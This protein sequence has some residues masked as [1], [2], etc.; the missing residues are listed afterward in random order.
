M[1]NFR[2]QHIKHKE[3]K[4]IHSHKVSSCKLSH[5]AKYLETIP[6]S[7]NYLI[8]GLQNELTKLGILKNQEDYE[9]FWKLTQEVCAIK[10]LTL[11]TSARTKPVK[12]HNGFTNIGVLK[13][14]MAA[15]L[16]QSAGTCQ[17]PSH[18]MSKQ[19]TTQTGT[20]EMFPKSKP[21]KRNR[22][23]K[24]H[25]HYLHHMH[26]FSLVNMVSSKRMLEKNGQFSGVRT[27]QSVHDLMEYLFP[28]RHEQSGMNHNIKIMEENTFPSLVGSKQQEMNHKVSSKMY[29][30][31]KE[32]KGMLK[33]HTNKVVGERAEDE[34]CNV[35]TFAQQEIITVPLT[36]EDA[37][38]Y[39][40]VVEVK[41]RGTDCKNYPD[42][43]SING[44]S[45]NYKRS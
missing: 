37:S 15:S 43:D 29:K 20:K 1:S 26:Y 6:Q 11:S 28:N 23:Y 14:S 3:K 7:S 17:L 8:I 44:K 41:P 18:H 13:K 45:I 9:N 22:R 4:Y 25:L 32:K 16:L 39:H 19:V 27:E 30:G 24:Q 34:K 5:D 12:H 36:L 10:P 35:T 2:V 33:Q 21:C 40:P 31:S 38:L 42:K